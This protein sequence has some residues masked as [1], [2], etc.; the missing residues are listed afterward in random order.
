MLETELRTLVKAELHRGKIDCI[1]HFNANEENQNLNI[2]EDLLIT[3]SLLEDRVSSLTGAGK[4]QNAIEY[5]RW[6]GI[7]SKPDRDVDSQHQLVTSLFR[8]A[9]N[10]L[11]A[12]RTREG[13]ELQQIIEGKLTQL[14]ETNTAI[15]AGAPAHVRAQQ[16]KLTT[17]LSKL[18]IEADAGRLEQEMVL[19]ASRLGYRG[20]T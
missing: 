8:E 9:L 15:R 1:L 10:S 7:I 16:Q 5:L 20:R 13:V 4:A 6:P 19:I 12:M 14:S 18:N 3:L 2:N 11:I 17:R